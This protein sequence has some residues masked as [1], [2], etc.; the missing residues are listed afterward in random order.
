MMLTDVLLV[1]TAPPLFA[2]WVTKIFG[3]RTPK[4]S[5]KERGAGNLLSR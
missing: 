2:E 1:R 3:I 5:A 4:L